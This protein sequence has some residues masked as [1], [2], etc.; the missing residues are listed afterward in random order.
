MPTAIKYDH[1]HWT[2]GLELE[3]GDWDT[4]QGWEGFGR[5]PEPNICNSN[6]I[7]T[8]PT[9]KSYPF[10]GEINT[11]PTS[12]PEEQVALLRKFLKSHPRAVATHRAG[13][14]VHIRIPGLI[15][16]L[17]TLKRLQ[18]YITQ[19]TDAYP[20]V[21]PLP[22]PTRS[23][24]CSAEEYKGAKRRQH[25]MRMSH[26]TAIPIN[27]VEKQ[28]QATTVKEFL[29]LE[30]PKS[31]AGAVLWHAQPRAA[32]NLRQLKQ[33]ETIE[34]RH[35][36]AT[37]SPEETLTAIKWCRDYVL[38]CLDSYPACELFQSKYARQDFP[39]TE[40]YLHWRE[41]RW[42]ATSIT[43]HKR[44]VIEENIKLILE[45][46]FDDIDNQPYAYLNP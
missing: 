35:Y 34:F 6:G 45:E 10:G 31:R 18:Q 38:A 41:L 24:F 9:L 13:L 17:P 26:W 4:R 23:D 33:T 2:F 15:S 1:K 5:D 25:W 20:L 43:K 42:A 16:H 7:A 8:D 39:K 29:D 27:R 21:D 12:T 14:H 22:L 11:P 37:T 46:Q 19:N 32:I 28:L 3:F 30:V 36:S 44:S 40:P